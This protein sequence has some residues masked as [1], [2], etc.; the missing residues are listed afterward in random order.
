MHILMGA[1]GGFP[2]SNSQMS[3]LKIRPNSIVYPQ[4]QNHKRKKT[5]PKTPKS[6]TPKAP[7]S[8]TSSNILATFPHI[9]QTGILKRIL[10]PLSQL[11]E[12]FSY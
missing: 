9:M 2:G 4:I 7:K 5:K 6:K 12:N 8:K 1:L 3:L 11:K 10:D